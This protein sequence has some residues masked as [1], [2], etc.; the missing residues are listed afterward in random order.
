M[1]SFVKDNVSCPNNL[2]LRWYPDPENVGSFIAD[3]IPNKCTRFGFLKL[4]NLFIKS[5][6]LTSRDLEVEYRRFRLPNN[7]V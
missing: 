1:V 5:V 4:R 7:F 3:E 2:F 6:R